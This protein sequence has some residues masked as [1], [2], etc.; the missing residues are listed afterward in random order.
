MAQGKYIICIYMDWNES[1]SPIQMA[2]LHSEVFQMKGIKL[3][4][5]EI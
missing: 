1:D 5:R 3:H 2:V 4:L